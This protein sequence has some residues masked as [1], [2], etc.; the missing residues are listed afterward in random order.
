MRCAPMPR[1]AR[2]PQ[3]KRSSIAAPDVA[4]GF[5]VHDT[6]A[7]RKVR[8]QPATERGRQVLRLYV[9]GV[10]PYDSGHMGHAFTFCAFDILVRFVEAAGVRV[11]YVTDITDVDD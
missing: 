4:F 6:L 8:L 11:R 1:L 5:R 3:S 10:T 7:G 2:V 9:C